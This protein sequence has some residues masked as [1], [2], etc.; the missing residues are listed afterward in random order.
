MRTAIHK[1][2]GSIM[3]NGRLLENGLAG[4]PEL[5][6]I[7]SSYALLG[8]SDE[9]DEPGAWEYVPSGQ[10]VQACADAAPSLSENFPAMHVRHV[11]ADVAARAS[12]YFPRA[13]LVQLLS[14]VA[15][16]TI[17]NLPASHDE[18]LVREVLEYFPT[19]HCRQGLGP[20][21]CLYLPGMH[22]SHAVEAS[23]PASPSAHCV[24][25]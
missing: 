17:E 7:A 4:D 13:H 10:S 20:V 12:E 1:L 6:G 9:S 19:A 18:Q 22:R 23:Q 14:E 24:P 16:R 25:W 2:G 8:T 15:A 21:I 3:G 5:R 11:A